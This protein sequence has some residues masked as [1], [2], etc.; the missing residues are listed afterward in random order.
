M[1]S[2]GTS[3]V[4]PVS[5]FPVPSAFGPA[6]GP[7]IG[8]CCTDPRITPQKKSG[9]LSGLSGSFRL[10]EVAAREKGRRINP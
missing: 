6:A 4:D 3:G 10:V 5:V 9:Y 2:S 7:D 8:G 1:P